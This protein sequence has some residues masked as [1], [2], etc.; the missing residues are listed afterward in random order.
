MALKHL[1]YLDIP[2]AK[3]KATATKAIIRLKETLS[4]PA[5]TSEQK[6]AIHNR[7]AHLSKWVAGARPQTDH[8]VTV[9]ETVSVEES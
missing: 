5:L 4:N 9:E 3:R 8:V 7:L 6:D 2:P 1:T